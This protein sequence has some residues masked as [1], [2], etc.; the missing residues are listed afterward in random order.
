MSFDEAVVEKLNEIKND[1]NVGEG[2]GDLFSSMQED[3]QTGDVTLLEGI[4]FR[5][6][7]EIGKQG[8]FGDNHIAA[9]L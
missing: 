1:M 4:M 5:S 3:I 7:S 2:E 8:V 6:S 9:L